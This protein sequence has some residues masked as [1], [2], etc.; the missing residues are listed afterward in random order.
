MKTFNEL[1]LFIKK[2]RKVGENLVVKL[3][4]VLLPKDTN[5]LFTIS[6]VQN[7]KLA[8]MQQASVI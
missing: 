7:K 6:R 5:Q 3:H 1:N 4:K 2:K 8:S